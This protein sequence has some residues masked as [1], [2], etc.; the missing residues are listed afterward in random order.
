MCSAKTPKPPKP[1][2]GPPGPNAATAMILK[3]SKARRSSKDRD[4]LGRLRI[5]LVETPNEAIPQ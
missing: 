5:P 4:I 1:P 2:V 3:P